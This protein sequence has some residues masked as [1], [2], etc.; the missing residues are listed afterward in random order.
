MAS[1]LGLRTIAEGV[2][3]AEQLAFLRLKGCEEVQG[4]YFSKPLPAE[5]FAAYVKESIRLVL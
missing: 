1:E 4:Y 3:T 5:Q 2:E